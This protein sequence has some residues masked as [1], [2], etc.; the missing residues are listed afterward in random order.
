MSVRFTLQTVFPF[1][2]LNPVIVDKCGHKGL[3]GVILFIY[4]KCYITLFDKVLSIH[5]WCFFFQKVPYF[6]C[7]LCVLFFY[8]FFNNIKISFQ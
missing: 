1:L 3:R 6:L 2:A 8:I 4:Y 5:L 7:K